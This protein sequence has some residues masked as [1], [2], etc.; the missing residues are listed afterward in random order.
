MAKSWACC[1]LWLVSTLLPSAGTWT[2][3]GTVPAC[4]IE[5]SKPLGVYTETPDDAPSDATTA[6]SAESAVAC[7]DSAASD[8]LETTGTYD[9]AAGVGA[10]TELSVTVMMLTL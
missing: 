10:V 8:V 2:G 3:A 6:D 4:T 5:F 1:A 9:W 7:E